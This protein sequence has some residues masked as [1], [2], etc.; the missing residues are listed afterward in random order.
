MGSRLGWANE[1]SVLEGWRGTWE[2]WWKYELKPNIF[3]RPSDSGAYLGLYVRDIMQV[4]PCKNGIFQS[5]SSQQPQKTERCPDY[6]MK[7][8]SVQRR[9]LRIEVQDYV[10]RTLEVDSVMFSEESESG[11]SKYE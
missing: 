9:V 5:V 10:V 11:T 4:P 7:T 1:V 2:D 6:W 3:D 8:V